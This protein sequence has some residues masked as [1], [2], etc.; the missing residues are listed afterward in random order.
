M[1]KQ[2]LKF[3]FYPGRLVTHMSLYPG[4]GGKKAVF[5]LYKGMKIHLTPTPCRHRNASYSHII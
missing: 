4:K 1:F 3:S 2:F 5:I